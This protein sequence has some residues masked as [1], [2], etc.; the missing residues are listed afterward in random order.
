MHELVVQI[1]RLGHFVR[2]SAQSGQSL[3]INKNSQRICPSNQHVNPQVEL[4]SLDQEGLAHVP[5]DDTLFIFQLLNK[6]M[7]TVDV[8]GEEDASTLATGFRLTNEG[9]GFALL[10]IIVVLFEV[11]EFCGQAPSDGEEVVVL[12]ELLSELHEA[13]AE[14]VFS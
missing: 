6:S 11:G 14:E 4:E 13:F 3:I 10:S 1:V 7:V 12:W 9:L 8:S 5:L 2:L